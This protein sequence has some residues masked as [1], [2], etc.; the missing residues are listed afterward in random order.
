MHSTL[1]E[2]DYVRKITK[3]GE[4]LQGVVI[5]VYSYT[6]PPFGRINERGTP[7]LI[8]EILEESYLHDDEDSDEDH[9]EGWELSTK[10]E[11]ENACKDYSNARSLARLS[12]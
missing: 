6:Y 8:V 10:E 5:K 2:D 11:Y 9:I 1:K 3:Y 12:I 4:V 7:S